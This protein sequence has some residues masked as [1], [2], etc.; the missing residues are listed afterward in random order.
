MSE[1]AGRSRHHEIIRR[2]P[3]AL[4]ATTVRVLAALI[5]AL[6]LVPTGTHATTAILVDDAAHN[7]VTGDWFVGRSTGAAFAVESWVVNFGNRG[8]TVEEVFSGVR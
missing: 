7:Q 6:L 5:A 1:H 2:I 4:G 3:R 8:E